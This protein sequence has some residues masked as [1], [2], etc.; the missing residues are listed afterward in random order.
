MLFTRGC[1]G[2]ELVT[3]LLNELR[4]PKTRPR[5]CLL[6]YWRRSGGHG[7]ICLASGVF[8]CA[9]TVVAVVLFLFGVVFLCDISCCVVCFDVFCFVLHLFGVVFHC[10]IFFAMFWLVSLCVPR[11]HCIDVNFLCC[12]ASGT[13]VHEWRS[14]VYL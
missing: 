12:F 10:C 6:G 13:V 2:K 1:D 9:G 8:A 7:W 14:G 4:L 3:S 11:W 5:S